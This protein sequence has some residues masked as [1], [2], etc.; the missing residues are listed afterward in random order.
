MSQCLSHVI[1]LDVSYN[2]ISVFPSA[3]IYYMSTLENLYFQHN[4]LVD[5]PANAFAD[6]KKLK[7]IN[8]SYNY[9]TTYELSFGLVATS[10]DFSNNQIS[11]IT[12]NFYSN[13]SGS[14]FI[15]ANVYL[16]NNSPIIN[17]TD[18]VYEMYGSCIEANTWLNDSLNTE[19]LAYPELTILLAY[20]NFGTSRINCSCDQSYIVRIYNTV[21]LDEEDKSIWPLY[22]ATCT[23]GEQFIRNLCTAWNST[24]SS[25]NFAQVY[26]RQCKIYPDEDG[27]ITSIT[28][29]VTVPSRNVVSFVQIHS[30]DFLFYCHY[31]LDNIS[32]F[33]K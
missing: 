22:T 8:F 7:I 29:N 12:N 24:N 30:K 16:T 27:S 17:L 4:A 1:T 32:E 9:L 11:T 2:N 6:I 18:A 20:L 5:I 33:D 28:Q 19:D 23:N 21:W 10:A 26:P 15:S 25:A 3:L 13:I 14:D 31:F